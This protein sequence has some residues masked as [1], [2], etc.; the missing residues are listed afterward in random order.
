MA[1]AFA[2]PAGLPAGPC[3][4]R[5]LPAPGATEP[6]SNPAPL[7]IAPEPSNATVAAGAVSM[8]V[9]PGV[10]AGQEVTL[11]LD[12][13]IAHA[14]ITVPTTQLAFLTN[15][16]AAGSYRVRIRVDGVDNQFIDRVAEPPVLV[17]DEVTVP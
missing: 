13:A 14:P 2:I 12:R 1:V 8:D 6:A 10:V 3:W 5:A 4:V 17:G 7:A 15:D 16:V 9:S 11:Y